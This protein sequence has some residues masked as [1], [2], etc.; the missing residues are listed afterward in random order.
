[1][2]CN[3]DAPDDDS[4]GGWEVMGATVEDTTVVTAL[5]FA[6][7]VPRSGVVIDWERTATEV[8]ATVLGLVMLAC[9]T[10]PN[11]VINIDMSPTVETDG[12]VP[13]VVGGL[14]LEP[15]PQPRLG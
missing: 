2:Y 8:D 9:T 14:G 12:T 4:R 6:A 5:V 7:T 3:T 10:C 1:M 15:R 13:S 11:R